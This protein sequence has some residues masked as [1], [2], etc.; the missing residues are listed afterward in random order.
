MNDGGAS[1]NAGGGISAGSL[2]DGWAGLYARF[3]FALSV[4]LGGGAGRDGVDSGALRVSVFA[5]CCACRAIFF[6]WWW[7]WL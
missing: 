1:G 4:G 7:G 3:A 6:L 2:S 5:V